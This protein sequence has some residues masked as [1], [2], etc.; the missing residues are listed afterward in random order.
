MQLEKMAAFVPFQQPALVAPWEAVLDVN[1]TLMLLDASPLG[2]KCQISDPPKEHKVL[3][4][5]SGYSVN[6]KKKKNPDSVG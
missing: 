2:F 4:C 1:L 3:K 6:K 5:Q